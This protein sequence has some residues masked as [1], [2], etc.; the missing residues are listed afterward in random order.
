MVGL[1]AGP[2]WPI[3]ASKEQTVLPLVKG[4]LFCFSRLI[5]RSCFAE[6]NCTQNNKYKR[7]DFTG[8]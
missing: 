7:A 2:P 8:Y 3:K 4:P 1:Q 5:D 6:F